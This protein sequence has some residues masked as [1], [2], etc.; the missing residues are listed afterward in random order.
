MTDTESLE[1]LQ[2]L[3]D[4]QK[5]AILADPNPSLAVRIE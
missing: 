1:R 2:E 5:E 4:G 3:F